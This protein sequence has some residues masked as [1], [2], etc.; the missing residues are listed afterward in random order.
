MLNDEQPASERFVA[1][2]GESI[3]AILETTTARVTVGITRTR[4]PIEKEDRVHA[5]EQSCGRVGVL[6]IDGRTWI[7]S[8]QHLRGIVR[9]RDRD[10]IDVALG[11]NEVALRELGQHLLADVRHVQ[12]H[13]GEPEH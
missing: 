10:A 2:R 13:D 12:L 8:I 11:M 3:G 5:A 7:R 6:A 1:T 9:T 4:W